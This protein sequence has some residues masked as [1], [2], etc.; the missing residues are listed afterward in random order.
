MRVS[1]A[2]GYGLCIT[3]IRELQRTL[4][5]PKSCVAACQTQASH[6]TQNLGGRFQAALVSDLPCR[7]RFLGLKCSIKQE[8]TSWTWT[9]GRSLVR[10]TPEC[11][12][13][14]RRRTRTRAPAST[15]KSRRCGRG[16]T[17]RRTCRTVTT[18]RPS[19]R[20]RGPPAWPPS[21]R[22]PP[23]AWS[24]CI[25]AYCLCHDYCGYA[26]LRVAALCPC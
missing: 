10:H 8:L 5:A 15:P 17:S 16:R 7:G 18:R 22:L 1:L 3:I 20:S 9:V 12:P 21:P 6:T 13:A 26:N 4:P 19:P 11:G 14:S 23:A 25:F 2:Y 24:A